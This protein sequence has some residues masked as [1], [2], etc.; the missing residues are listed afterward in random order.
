MSEAGDRWS[1]DI[2]AIAGRQ[3]TAA[4][5]RLF[6]EFA[7][8][9]KSYLLGQGVDA[10]RAEELSQEVM[11]SVWRAAGTFHPGKATAAAWIFT[12]ARNRRIDAVRRERHP[13]DLMAG[14]LMDREPPITPEDALCAEQRHMSLREALAGMSEE[15]RNV[16]QMSFFQG[17]PHAQIARD[18]DLPL[19]TVKSRLRLAVRQL[20]RL[21]GVAQ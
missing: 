11:V 6:A 8:R 5:G 14:G 12:I 4:F 10:Q 20:R 13:S 19:G 15:H 17:R 21:L 1:D 18:L 2:L 16:L 3:D 7:P 9:V